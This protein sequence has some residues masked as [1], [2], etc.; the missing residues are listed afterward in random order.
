MERLKDNPS[1]EVSEN[2]SVSAITNRLY[3]FTESPQKVF[4]AIGL[5]FGII[6]LILT[7]P[8]LA[9][10]EWNHWKRAYFTSEGNLKVKRIP[11]ARA[12][13]V[14]AMLPEEVLIVESLALLNLPYIK[15]N[16]KQLPK[17]EIYNQDE[18]LA[19]RKFSKDN[20]LSLFRRPAAQPVPFFSDR[21]FVRFPNTAYYSPHLY[22]PQAAGIALGRLL[23]LPIIALMYV[24]RFINLIVWL[25]LM[26]FAIRNTPVLKWL[27][28]LYALTPTSLFQSSSLSPDSLTNALS[29][30]LLAVC[31]R[32]AY[33]EKEGKAK[34]AIIFT[35]A[36][37]VSVSKLYFPLIL[38]YLLVPKE[39]VGSGKKYWIM[40]FLL[41]ILSAI[42]V[43]LWRYYA[44]DIFVPL[45]PGA[46]PDDQL[47]YILKH[48]IHYLSIIW[49]SLLDEG[50]SYVITFVG[51]L[52]HYWHVL[53]MWLV[54]VHM[55]ALML[56]ALVDKS[57]DVIISAKDRALLLAV[58]LLGSMCVFTLQYLSWTTVG[59]TIV[60]GVQ[61][62]YF[63]PVML[64]FFLLFQNRKFT[65]DIYRKK[66]HWLISCYLV[67]VLAFS[68]YVI[69]E[70][71]YL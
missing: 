49:N 28:L 24:G 63:I 17:F 65:F 15:D 27:F 56:V 23:G 5:I 69:I 26:Y 22:L 42:A 57:E 13:G 12:A 29:I 47:Y 19:V 35:L 66:I 45:N 7:P 20:L 34:L 4:L 18:Y 3:S 50:E 46:S 9:P 44:Q 30:L 38:L 32:Y 55:S 60:D 70:G 31:L 68:S 14:G 37:L 54:V 1:A 53:P 36:L 6:F 64:P 59:A 51:R 8:F 41:C 67:S 10:D 39:K 43:L 11:D 71:Y 33:D 52:G 62:R 61:G 2:K 58:F 48:P 40:F 25:S 21:L 16:I